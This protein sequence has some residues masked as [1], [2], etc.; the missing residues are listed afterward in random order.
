MKISTFFTVALT[1]FSANVFGQTKTIL[2]NRGGAATGAQF[3]SGGLSTTID[4]LS[5]CQKNI[6][7]TFSCAS[8]NGTWS[9]G[10]YD[11][12]VNGNK[13]GSYSGTLTVD[14][15][16]YIPV[17]SIKMVK[18]NYANWNQQNIGV[19]LT[20]NASSMPTNGPTVSNLDYCLNS[21]ASQLTATLNGTGKSL[22]WYTTK[23][24]DG[25]SANAYTPATN[26][27]DTF[28]W[29]V[30][31]ADSLGCESERSTIDV[32]VYP[33]PS[34][35]IV[36]NVTYGQNQISL[37]LT[38]T[39]TGQLLW[40]ASDTQSVGSTTAPT[41]NTTD[42]GSFHYWV[43]QKTGSCESPKSMI[44][45]TIYPSDN[46][47]YSQGAAATAS[48]FISN[49][50]E[51]TMDY[52]STC[53]K[54]VTAT[55]WSGSYG[56]GVWSDGN[57]EYYVNGNKIGTSAGTLKLDLNSYMPITSLKIKKTDRANWNQ[58]N[59]TVTI[60]NDPSN[61]TSSKPTVIDPTYLCKGSTASALTAAVN[62]NGKTLK[63]YINKYG[64][65]YNGA[66]GFT[67]NTTTN[68]TVSYYVAQ[69]DSLGCESQR[70]KISV[71][72][73]ENNPMVYGSND[74]LYVNNALGAYQWYKYDSDTTFKKIDGATENQYKA[75]SDGTYFAEVTI[76]GCTQKSNNFTVAGM[77]VK[78]T[79]M[80][81][82]VIYP[83]PTTGVLNIQ[84]NQSLL[85]AQINIYDVTGRF[86]KQSISNTNNPI[87]SVTDI[88]S[89]TY[90]VELKKD[91]ERK[92]FK[93]IKN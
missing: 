92:N 25:Y 90:T 17:T 24:G 58:V 36:T 40:Y 59:I 5:T 69:A 37:P 61:F 21:S 43:S 16:P 82:V 14:L 71:I 75:M 1:L 52:L 51:M 76:S 65:G 38:A 44:T 77:A 29:W 50:L 22:K 35:P 12:Y 8:Y 13:I 27:A 20:S 15:T 70:A 23:V 83:N 11:Y 30:A 81:Q 89:G 88:Q 67:P 68:D 32:I 9:N 10:N 45:V 80:K 49:G 66:T 54:N 46:L 3:N 87:I 57:F 86:V 18:T 2:Y 47:I 84:S 39:A 26:V 78:T 91:G 48:Q 63:W 7:V 55:F 53:Q 64:E 62:N 42:T 73:I 56:N 19:S 28:T 93:I 79:S 72:N 41:P 85:G 74:T 33:I 4:Y 31:Q 6:S 60:A 34:A